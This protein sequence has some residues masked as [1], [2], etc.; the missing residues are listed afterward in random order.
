VRRILERLTGRF[1]SRIA[2]AAREAVAGRRGL[3]VGGPSRI[4]GPKGR[5]PL[6]PAVAALD[7][8]DYRADTRRHPER[9]AAEGFRFRRGGPAGRLFL[10]EAVDLQGVPDGVYDFVLASHV[11]EHVADP[12][13]ALRSWAR[14]VGD[15]GRLVLVVPHREGT[16]DH[17]RPV[18]PLAH[19]VADQEAGTG[20]DDLTHLPEVLAHHD[21][22]RDPG[23]DTLEALERRGRD[24]LRHRALH[25]HVFDTELVLGALDHA[26][27]QVDALDVMRPYHVAVLARRPAGARPDNA[28][29]WGRDAAWRA[30]SPF[31]GDRGGRD[32]R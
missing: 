23:V 25:H 27:W 31:P 8:A 15:E 14:V 12:L 29:W 9:A 2:A 26:G 16:F 32:S 1:R 10:C 13:R 17:R 19:L 6:Y 4:F 22:A 7:G 20:E 21:L 3:E 30:R 11:L 18:T 5:I 24:N 28:A